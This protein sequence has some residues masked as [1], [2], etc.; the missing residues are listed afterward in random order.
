[1][2]DQDGAVAAAFVEAA[3]HVLAEGMAKIEHCISQLNDAAVWWR[4]SEARNSIAN[5]M[6]HLTGNLRQW[7]VSGVGG[8]APDVRNRPQE[9]ADR[10]GRP[11]AKLLDLLRRTVAEADAVLSRLT[12]QDL[13]RPRRIQGFETNVLAAVF[14]TVAHFRGHTQ[15]IIHMTRAQLGD[16]YV[17]YFVPEGPE[18]TSAGGGV[19]EAREPNPMRGQRDGGNDPLRLRPR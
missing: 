17:F 9:F 15:E 2:T 19:S 13:T 14:D 10:S 12:A 7:I 1:M 11:K 18:Q 6:L 3:R 16:R 8:A 5:L 4:P